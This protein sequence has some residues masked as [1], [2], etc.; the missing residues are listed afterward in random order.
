[1]LRLESLT[2]QIIGAAI[3]VHKALG[4]GLLASVCQAALARELELRRIPFEREKVI[5]V[6]YKGVPWECGFVADF[7]VAGKVILELKTVSDLTAI[8]EAQCLN[9]MRLA[10]CSVELPSNFND[11]LLKDGVKRLV[12]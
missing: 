9:Y 7:L 3:E 12:I 10:D 4:P 5:P 6:T 8:R 1:M 2:E 11:K